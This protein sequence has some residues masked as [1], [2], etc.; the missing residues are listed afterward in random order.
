MES[1]VAARHS[2]S[3][4]RADSLDGLVPESP[5]QK[6]PNEDDGG[7]EQ[8]RLLEH[9]LE[10]YELDDLDPVNGN[11][12]KYNEEDD[13]PYPEVRAAVRNYDE[14]VPCG[15]VR[16]WTI[17]LGLVVIGA[18]MN[19]L[20]SLRQPTISVTSLLAQVVA[21]PL[22]HAWAAI[23]PART[24]TT[25]GR[26]WSLN[27]GPFNIKEHSI[28]VVMAGV[29]FSVAYST[30]IILAQMIFYKQNF[31]LVFQILL[32]ICTQSLGYGMAGVMRKFLVYPAAMIWPTNLVNVSLMNAMHDKHDKPDPRVFGGSMSRYKWFTLVSAVSFFY[33]FLPGYLAKCLSLFAPLT[34][35]APQNV[36]VNQLFGEN[37]GMSLLPITFDWS[38]IAGYIGSPMMTPW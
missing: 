36:V 17:G 28:I 20:F 3:L 12:K 10:D 30:D 5:D 25:F 32:T 2:E 14:D 7:S 34:W 37:S 4:E 35:L 26:T 19:T 13:S 15:T 1:H 24:F 6:R 9:D 27:P 8:E 23:V 11:A 16:A 38:Q 21:Y 22:G 18:S 29:S 31:G 33:F